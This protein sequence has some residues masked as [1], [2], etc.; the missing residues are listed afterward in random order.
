MTAARTLRA[1]LNI[2]ASI[3][4]PL[5]LNGAIVISR[6]ESRIVQ[7]QGEALALAALTLLVGFAF[8]IFEFRM[9]AALIAIVYFPAMGFLLIE[10]EFVISGRL[11]HNYL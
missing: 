10:L 7:S 9:Y 6:Y 11:Y 1:L 8:L 5:V 3:V 4:V 2:V